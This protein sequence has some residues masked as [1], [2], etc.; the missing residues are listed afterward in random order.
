MVCSS[1]K[2]YMTYIAKD[3]ELDD[4][5]CS[6]DCK[7]INYDDESV[8]YIRDRINYGRGGWTNESMKYI[9][10]HC[11]DNVDD[12][13]SEGINKK[14]SIAVLLENAEKHTTYFLDDNCGNII[15]VNSGTLSDKK[16]KFD[17]K[18]MSNSASSK[19]EAQ[20][21][22]WLHGQRLE[23]DTSDDSHTSDDS[24]ILD[25]I[26]KIKAMY[27]EFKENHT[28]GEDRTAI[29][30][31]LKSQLKKCNEIKKAIDKKPDEKLLKL[32]TEMTNA[33]K[34]LQ[35]E[36]E[37]GNVK[38]SESEKKYSILKGEPEIRNQKVEEEKKKL[39]EEK[40]KLEGEKKKLEEEKKKLR[41]ELEESNSLREKD[42]A[43]CEKDVAACGENLTKCIKTVDD[44]NLKIKTTS[45]SISALE[46][47]SNELQKLKGDF[48]SLKKDSNNKDADM[49]ALET[50]LLKLDREVKKYKT[51]E[52]GYIEKIQNNEKL[53]EANKK[54]LSTI[55]EDRGEEIE[56]LKVELTNCGNSIKAIKKSKDDMEVKLKLLDNTSLENAR[57]T[58]EVKEISEKCYQDKQRLSE[59]INKLISDD[60]DSEGKIQQLELENEYLQVD[61]LARMAEISTYRLNQDKY[62]D[63]D[64]M[65]KACMSQNTKKSDEYEKLLEQLK[66]D[67]ENINKKY[68]DCEKRI[69][70][71]DR[72]SERLQDRIVYERLQDKSVWEK[73]VK[74]KEK[75]IEELRKDMEGVVVLGNRS[76]G[77]VVDD[78]DDDFLIKMNNIF[79]KIDSNHETLISEVEECDESRKETEKKIKD[80]ENVVSDLNEKIEELNDTHLVEIAELETEKD[81]IEKA[82]K[83]VEK[84]SISCLEKIREIDDEITDLISIMNINK[85]E[86]NVSSD[87][88]INKLRIAIETYKS[89]DEQLKKTGKQLE[90]SEKEI[91]ELKRNY[92]RIAQINK[93]LELDNSDNMKRYSTDLRGVEEKLKNECND[94]TTKYML[95]SQKT[96][97]KEIEDI[98][99]SHKKEL[100]ALTIRIDESSD[101]LREYT[102]SKDEQ[103]RDLTK[104]REANE[105][106]IGSLMKGL[107]NANDR[108]DLLSKQSRIVDP[109]MCNVK[110][111][112]LTEAIVIL[113]KLRLQLDP[114]LHK[115]IEE[116]KKLI[117]V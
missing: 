14:T 65:Y 15:F 22:Q 74:I 46:I 106:R 51:Q 12:K 16:Y 21:P 1:Q 89:N 95:E 63:M 26:S 52:K 73:E 13:W 104:L 7:V 41:K 90:L 8:I 30:N 108:I 23:I 36:V 39:E 91:D 107:L 83:I 70:E 64:N 115:D 81:I 88:M 47:D 45:A 68:K 102:K 117:A 54:I 109:N 79:D 17:D 56:K 38:L 75:E 96:C 33:I 49:E 24:Y 42:V 72:E 71:L 27:D 48:E 92:D 69:T 67:K 103:I 10:S 4:L 58:E 20:D 35:K 29:I 3:S 61:L 87:P 101:K 100:D 82:S 98:R 57:L 105:K 97:T 28:R 11:I 50:K 59:E 84:D 114:A 2:L 34:D 18:E 62:K 80:C 55:D 85:E 19:K 66:N 53:L 37:K 86:G 9:I 111:E 93:K 25:E 44:L 40:K 99:S 78:D 5:Q 113:N 112:N 110:R 6:D 60:G 76:S 32:N 31:N 77:V 116:A 94:K 43:A